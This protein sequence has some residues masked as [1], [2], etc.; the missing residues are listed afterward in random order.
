MTLRISRREA[1]SWA[2]A[3]GALGCR[4]GTEPAPP[5]VAASATAASLDWGGLAVSHVTQ[6]REDERG[7]I[8]VVLLHGYGASG[9]DLVPLAQALLQARTRFILPRA[10]IQLSG[11]G[12][13]WWEMAVANRPRTVMDEPASGGGA[14]STQLAFA[15]RAVQ[16]VLR[17][18]VQRYQPERLAIAGF[19][20]GAMLALDVA[21]GAPP[22]VDRVALLSGALLVDAAARLEAP[23]TTRPAVFISHGRDDQRLPFQGGERTVAALTAASFSV[24]FR[25]F[26][27]GHEIP[28]ALM[29]D[30]A[31]FLLGA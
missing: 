4:S 29:G 17:T 5:P 28:E 13:A 23:L 6:L 9:T 3:S 12:R 18:A 24:K 10:P 26:D 20:Q 25:P 15:F 14:P 19:S 31:A 11:S 21:L 2:L 16:G 8:A 7:G 1:L 30:L 22:A 27:G